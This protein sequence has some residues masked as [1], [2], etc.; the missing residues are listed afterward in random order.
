LLTHFHSPL[1]GVQ[2]ASQLSSC[3]PISASL[4]PTSLFGALRLPTPQQQHSPPSAAHS[5]IPPSHFQFETLALMEQLKQRNLGLEISTNPPPESP[6]E[7]SV[8]LQEWKASRVL[9][10]PP[11][12][13]GY[14]PACIKGVRSNKD[15]DS[16]AEHI[17]EDVMSPIREQPDI[18]AD[19]APSPDSINVLDLLCV[20]WKSDE[21]VYRLAEVV[22]KTA[23]PARF[24][25]RLRSGSSSEC[26]WLPRA[27]VR[28]L[29]PPWYDELAAASSCNNSTTDNRMEKLHSNE[30]PC[31]YMLRAS[32]WRR[33]GIREWDLFHGTEKRLESETERTTDGSASHLE[34][35]QIV[36]D[37][38]K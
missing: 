15:F 38:N 3:D 35:A 21:N 9:A 19:Q 5:S 6:C 30:Y 7:V 4:Q 20:K 11:D 2:G 36:A 29:R 37:K 18:L 10:R 22:K 26:V 1:Q 33:V 24:Q 8:N 14:L 32:I 13:D 27:N 31:I 17:F 12:V 28:L 25:M 16:G 34:L 23:S